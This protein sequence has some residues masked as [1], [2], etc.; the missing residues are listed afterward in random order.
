MKTLLK[1]FQMLIIFTNRSF[2]GI[3]YLNA[4]Y[5]LSFIFPLLDAWDL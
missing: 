3:E 4:L 1:I 5:L 2:V